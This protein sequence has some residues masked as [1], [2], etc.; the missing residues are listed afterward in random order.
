MALA[1]RMQEDPTDPRPPGLGQIE[2]LAHAA[3]EALPEPFR[4]H[5]RAVAIRIEDLA[6]DDLLDEMGIDSPF[7]LTGVYQGVPL[8]EKSVSDQPLGPD[9]ITLFRRAI[10][11]EWIERGNVGLGQLV[12]HVLVHELAHHF[13]W[14]DAEIAAIDPWWEM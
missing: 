11:E 5:A 2:A 9:T 8:T 4:R 7:D 12:G 3:L 13:G 6:E 10:L 1:G 14:T